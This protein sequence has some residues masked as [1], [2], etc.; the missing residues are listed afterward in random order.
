MIRYCPGCGAE[1]T[2]GEDVLDGEII[3]CPDCGM[4]LE[5]ANPDTVDLVAIARDNPDFDTGG[6]D[7]SVPDHALIPAPN[8]EEDWGE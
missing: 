2:L 1:V 6:I 3:D 7:L 5:V 4:E 8:E